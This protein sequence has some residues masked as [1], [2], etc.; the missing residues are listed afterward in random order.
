MGKGRQDRSSL[1]TSQ[2]GGRKGEQ[3]ENSHSPNNL[4][5]QLET[6]GRK[7]RKLEAA[8]GSAGAGPSRR[9]NESNLGS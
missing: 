7:E 2:S 4:E 5:R 3:R 9:C 8:P 1:H 6:Q